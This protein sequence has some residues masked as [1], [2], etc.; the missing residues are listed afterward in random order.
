MEWGGGRDTKLGIK[1]P[2]LVNLFY[3]FDLY[4]L[5]ECFILKFKNTL[6]QKLKSSIIDMFSCF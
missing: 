4:I 3:K 1:M 2:L 5:K 6:K